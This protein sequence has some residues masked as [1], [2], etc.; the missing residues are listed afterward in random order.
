MKD[1]RNHH[2]AVDK[3]IYATICKLV[4]NFLHAY[5]AKVQS[6]FGLGNTAQIFLLTL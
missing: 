6:H 1:E 2:G 3:I 5:T 4:H